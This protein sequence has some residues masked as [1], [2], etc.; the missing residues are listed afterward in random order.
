MPKDVSHGFTYIGADG[1]TYLRLP[2]NGRPFRN[3]YARKRAEEKSDD[4]Q[5]TMSYHARQD[6]LFREGVIQRDTRVLNPAHYY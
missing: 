5:Y 4:T 6:E 3:E 2:E 1:H